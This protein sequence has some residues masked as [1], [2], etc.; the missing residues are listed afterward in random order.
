MEFAALP[1]GGGKKKITAAPM[2]ITAVKMEV[3]R[4]TTA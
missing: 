3:R 2:Q 4:G 1:C